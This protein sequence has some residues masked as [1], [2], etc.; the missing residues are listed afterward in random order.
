MPV[1]RPAPITAAS[2]GPNERGE[3]EVQEHYR[4]G[5][6]T[7][8]RPSERDPGTVPSFTVIREGKRPTRSLCP[9]FASPRPSFSREFGDRV[10]F[11]LWNATRKSAPSVAN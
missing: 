2:C 11:R 6:T 9:T 3:L 8:Y 4:D 1:M 7:Y 10:G 5:S